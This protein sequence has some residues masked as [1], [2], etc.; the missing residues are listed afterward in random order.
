MTIILQAF[1][2][3]YV[4]FSQFLW[5]NIFY[6]FAKKSGVS[7]NRI[8]IPTISLVIS[9]LLIHLY[10]GTHCEDQNSSHYQTVD[11]L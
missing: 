10:D 2:Q 9:D 1:T 11:L 8:P 6:N 4:S 7:W 5:I 3:K